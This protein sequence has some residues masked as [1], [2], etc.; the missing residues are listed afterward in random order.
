MAIS[1]LTQ[2][3]GGASRRSNCNPKPKAVILFLIFLSALR[4][5]GALLSVA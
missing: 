5:E 2:S 4:S 1:L 3:V